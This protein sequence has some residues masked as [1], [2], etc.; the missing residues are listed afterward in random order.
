MEN[1]SG[2]VVTPFVP[3][4]RDAFSTDLAGALL[5]TQRSD[6][7]LHE[8]AQPHQD[9]CSSLS[10]MD[11]S[12]PSPRISQEPDV[13]Y[14]DPQFYMADGSCVLRVRNTLFNVRFSYLLVR[15]K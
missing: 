11:A 7:P 5:P 13:P 15:D 1:D 12:Q 4:E 2:S 10:A 3:T 14:R 9:S 8:Q 6:S